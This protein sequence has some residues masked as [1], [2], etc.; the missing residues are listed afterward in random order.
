MAGLTLYPYLSC[1]TTPSEPP[2]IELTKF[3]PAE[4]HS[5]FDQAIA[6]AAASL[7]GSGANTGS[8]EARSLSRACTFASCNGTTCDR[9]QFYKQGRGRGTPTGAV[10][11]IL[12]KKNQVSLVYMT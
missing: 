2:S 4:S 8:A 9:T 3:A 11:P 10:V 7:V 1:S 6:P 5:E 12:E